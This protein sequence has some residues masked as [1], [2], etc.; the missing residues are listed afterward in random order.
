[1]DRAVRKRLRQCLVH[2][3]V[4]LEQRQL[5]EARALHRDVKVVAGPGPVAAAVGT[6]A[7]FLG[8]AVLIL[9]A[10]AAVLL[11]RDVRTI[12]RAG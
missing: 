6:R 3:P 5:L 9:V 1:M 8:S 7:T 11:S 4:L 12:E 10:T 2:E